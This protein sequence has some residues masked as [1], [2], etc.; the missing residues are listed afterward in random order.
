MNTLMKNLLRRL[1]G[2]RS[3]R[4]SDVPAWR[5]DGVWISVSL[6]THQRI[7][8][9]VD[10][11][12]QLEIANDAGRPMSRADVIDL[13]LEAYVCELREWVDADAAEQQRANG[14]RP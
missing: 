13:A 7:L 4:C 8:Q 5:P 1:T 12:H 6:E 11:H 9:A 3:I 14:G 10:L 2:R